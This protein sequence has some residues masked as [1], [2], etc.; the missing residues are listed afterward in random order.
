MISVDSMVNTEYS[1]V[2][3]KIILFRIS[4]KV[5]QLKIY[6]IIENI[7]GYICIC[8]TYA[9]HKYKYFLFCWFECIK[10]FFLV[11]LRNYIM[12]MFWIIKKIIYIKIL[13]LWRRT[14]VKWLSWFF[15]IVRFIWF[16]ETLM[17]CNGGYYNVLMVYDR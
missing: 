12:T 10:Y 5:P 2:D 4:S 11:M 9:S 6:W 7:I 8:K 14:L 15:N 16:C 17:V 3:T 13:I 1:E